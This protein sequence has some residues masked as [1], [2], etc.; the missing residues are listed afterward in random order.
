MPRWPEVQL[1]EK[2][3]TEPLQNHV[4]PWGRI[5]SVRSK[6]TLMGNRGKLHNNQKAIVRTW[7]NEAR[8]TCTLDVQKWGKRL[9]MMASNGCTE[10][11]VLDGTAALAAGYR[12]CDQCRRG[13][14]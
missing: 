14:T 1:P 9:R 3:T 6:R 10:L 4:D 8:I 13:L 2:G 7:R 5:C 11:F 12:P